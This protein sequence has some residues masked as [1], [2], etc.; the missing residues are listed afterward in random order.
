MG[1]GQV[2]RPPRL[3]R[4][5]LAEAQVLH[6]A[7]AGG[8]GLLPQRLQ[9]VLVRVCCCPQAPQSSAE[10]NKH[11]TQSPHTHTHTHRECFIYVR[12]FFVFIERPVRNDTSSLAC[13]TT[14]RLVNQSLST[15]RRH[16]NLCTVAI[17]AINLVRARFFFLFILFSFGRPRVG[18]LGW[19]STRFRAGAAHESEMNVRR[20]RKYPGPVNQ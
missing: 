16:A 13:Q 10:T 8:P 7:L 19:L 6:D 12:F 20:R 1:L 11:T 15:A 4:S 2:L 18:R 5:P 17:M 9:L 3:E 14:S